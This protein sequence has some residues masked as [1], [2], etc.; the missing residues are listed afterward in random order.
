[1]KMQFHTDGTNPPEMSIACNSMTLSYFQGTVIL[2]VDM[3]NIPTE[4]QCQIFGLVILI[5]PL[6]GWVTYQINADFTCTFN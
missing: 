1:M 3:F 5:P 6:N 2:R 4:E